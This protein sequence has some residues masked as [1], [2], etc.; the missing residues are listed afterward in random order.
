[1]S[2]TPEPPRSYR[3]T[4]PLAIWG[5]VLTFLFWPAGLVL[6]VLALR[7]VRRTG[8]GGWGLAVAGAAL[9][10]VAAVTTILGGL[11]LLARSDLPDRWSEQADARSDA[12]A[13]RRVIQDVEAD[14]LAQH[15]ADGAWPV[16]AGNRSVDDVRVD[17]YRTG[18]RLC[19]EG[20][21]GEY[22]AS[23]LDGEVEQDA[24][25]AERGVDQ[26]FRAAG[27]AD[28][29]G[30][31]SRRQAAL[32]DELVERAQVVAD[33]S[34][35]DGTP[36]LGLLNTDPADLQLCSAVTV[37]WDHLDDVGAREAF[38]LLVQDSDTEMQLMTNL[39]EEFA[40]V[41]DPATD[42]FARGL[43]YA[44]ASC[45]QGGFVGP[46]GDTPPLP[47]MWTEPLTQEDLDAD[48]ARVA[49]VKAG[50]PAA[51]ALSGSQDREEEAQIAAAIAAHL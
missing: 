16:D 21:R 46:G 38:W 17:A 2:E 40:D 20:S 48:E 49:G 27:Q 43:L 14:L 9:S 11:V 41:S 13:T 44:E 15:E 19:V 28:E 24:G 18:D 26:R 42:P 12:S 34:S 30:A 6:S 35:V 1:M 36:D 5:F 37:T 7:K 22:R 39:F 29:D 33:Q 8:D 45:W 51:I 50:D 3:D 32:L 4:E 25:C 10:T 31:E 23:V 47:A